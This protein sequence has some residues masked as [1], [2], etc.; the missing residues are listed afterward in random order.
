MICRSQLADAASTG[1]WFQARVV[2]HR[3]V[4]VEGDVARWAVEEDFFGLPGR[5]IIRPFVGVHED[6]EGVPLTLGVAVRAKE[7]R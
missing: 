1:E 6:D 7:D 2:F 3:L 5:W 4:E